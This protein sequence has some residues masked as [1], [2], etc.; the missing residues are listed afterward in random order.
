MARDEGTVRCGVSWGGL[1]RRFGL[2]R[3]SVSVD[4]FL[5]TGALGADVEV[6]AAGTYASKGLSGSSSI[7][8]GWIEGTLDAFTVSTRRPGLV[9]GG[10]TGLDPLGSLNHD[11]GSSFSINFWRSEASLPRFR[12]FRFLVQPKRSASSPES[13]VGSSFGSD[14][15]LSE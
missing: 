5:E 3:D 7:T 9:L 10:R 8:L 15:F 11:L 13:F 4:A 1:S 14:F 6:V 12:K 2:E